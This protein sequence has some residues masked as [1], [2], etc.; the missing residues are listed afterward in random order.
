MEEEIREDDVNWEEIMK[1]AESIRNY[2]K[3]ND[4]NAFGEPR[5]PEYESDYNEDDY[6]ED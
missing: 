4:C 2:N 5:H 1:S 6:D 3:D